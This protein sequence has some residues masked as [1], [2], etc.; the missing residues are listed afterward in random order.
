MKRITEL[1]S[2]IIIL[3]IIFYIYLSTMHPVFKTNDS[4]ETTVACVTLGIGHPPGYPIFVI[5][6]KIFSY[7]PIG[8][9]AFRINIFSSVFSLI[10]LLVIYNILKILYI[11]FFNNGY[12]FILFL[13]MLLIMAFSY[14]FWDQAIEAKGGIYML[15][16]LFLS[17]LIFYSIKL[18]YGFN[19]RYL[20]ILYFIFSL[21]LS[22]HW[23]SMIILSL[24]FLFFLLKYKNRLKPVNYLFILFLLLMGITP[25]LFLVIRASSNALLNWGDP[26]NLN[27]L[28]WVIL[29]KAYVY[30]IEPSLKVYLYQIKEYLV[31]TFIQS[32]FIFWI[33]SIIG[34]YFLYKKN[35]NIFIF[36]ISI[37]FIII[38]F[39]VFYNR[40]KQDVL[41]LMDI[42]LMPS[43][44]I[45]ILLSFFGILFIYNKLNSTI[46]KH[47]FLFL[48]IILIMIMFIIN[49]KF[50]NKRNDYFSYDYG[51]AIL[52]TIDENGVYIG[53]GDDNLMPV[54]YLQ[55]LMH[56]RKD[57]KFFTAS[58]L[59]F[60]WGI[61][62]YL[63]KYGNYD[64]KPYDTI[65][66]IE[67]ILKKEIN[68]NIYLSSFFPRKENMKYNLFET[69]KGILIK[70][71]AEKK[72][73]SSKIFKLYSYRYIFDN[74]CINSKANINL[75]TWYPVSM[76]NQAN[77]LVDNGF[78]NDA[79][80][81]YKMALNFPVN[82]PEARIYYN[83]ALA[84]S[85]VNDIDNEIIALENVIKRYPLLYAY[86]KLGILYYNTFI[87][88]KAK[89][90]FDKAIKMGS[91]NEYV[92]KGIEIIN[93]MSYNDML[94][95]AFIKANDF[96]S[97]NNIKT[98]QG[99]YNFL[100]EKNYKTAIIYR[101]IGVY[102][103]K[104]K[105]YEEALKNFLMSKNETYNSEISL[106]IGYTYFK[107]QKYE[108]ALNE[109][110]HG[111]LIFKDNIELKKLFNEI[112]ELKLKNEKDINSI[113][114]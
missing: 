42:F 107:M 108:E 46:K 71:S 109:L 23:P 60:Q 12:P 63:K 59:I 61:D 1:L 39:V 20:Y 102:Y 76:V 82:K 70:L 14:I 7:I 74:A 55:E 38:F 31:F 106:Y 53:D 27:N 5:L 58:F 95:L 104:T 62:Y 67:K 72:F 80:E 87:L 37:Y 24:V 65:N 84:Y 91:K 85:K 75:I 34:S 79:I 47:I 45:L 114:R 28:L 56:K 105:K 101:N 43:I 40:T 19:I 103:F 96:I 13:L 93:K 112:K 66:N 86:E 29:R 113:E 2:L 41:Y 10:I 57:I 94:E 68:N 6:G 8:N 32:N 35:R 52:N 25:Y 73:F 98:A 89:E 4:P 36:L 50:N 15:N 111:I 100:L 64:F 3:L 22:N 49:Y 78:I 33:F 77:V 18:F 26:K 17:L 48:I 88:P 81:L 69:N 99:L 44:Y 11:K 54:Y 51:N 83:L 92:L 97:K 110:Q 16:L 30:P 9:Y 21:S 90:M